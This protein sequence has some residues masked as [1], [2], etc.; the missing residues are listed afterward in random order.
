MNTR[1]EYYTAAYAADA[2]TPGFWSH[3]GLAAGSF[4]LSFGVFLAAAVVMARRSPESL[5]RQSMIP[6]EQSP[7]KTEVDRV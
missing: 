7:A 4:A 1:T 3:T 6:L 5:K 2:S